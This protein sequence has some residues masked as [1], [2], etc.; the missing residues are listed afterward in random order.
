MIGLVNQGQ[1]MEGI[2]YRPNN[3]AALEEKNIRLFLKYVEEKFKLQG[4]FGG[5]GC[6][7]FQK[8]A[9]FYVVLS[10]LSKL[11]ESIEKM[12]EIPKF[13]TSGRR[14]QIGYE[15][16]NFATNAIQG[17]REGDYH[18]MNDV[19][20]ERAQTCLDSAFEEL[21][22]FNAHFLNEILGAFQT[23]EKKNTSDLLKREF[24][25][26]FQLQKLK[27]LHA[28]LQVQ[29]EK[30][31]YCYTDIGR[32]FDNVKGDL[33]IYSK[34]IA[35]MK[36]AMTFY[37]NQMSENPDVIHAVEE[38]EQ[39][40]QMSINEL[41]QMIPQCAMRWPMLLE[42]IWRRAYKERRTDVEQDCLLY[43]SDAADE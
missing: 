8:F 4:L 22:A 21:I 38:M 42:A 7:V 11:S 17:Y 40:M 14:T 12:Y 32:V 5:F 6:Q 23:Y 26:V 30:L 10:G 2:I 39:N 16:N 29:L 19:K 20:L 18:F 31:H 24:F 28:G 3:I 15:D 9:N 13:H 35:Q 33:I 25:P 1:I 27:T 36:L 34:I 43:T 37:A 41:A